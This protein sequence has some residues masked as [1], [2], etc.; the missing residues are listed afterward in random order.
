[1][2][3]T[4]ERNNTIVKTSRRKI[5]DGSGINIQPVADTVRITK[6]TVNEL[7]LSSR[8][9]D[10]KSYTQKLHP[11]VGSMIR[12]LEMESTMGPSREKHTSH[13]KE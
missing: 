12:M 8:W 11:T 1:M 4:I 7:P 10:T 6:K 5:K 2:Q 3:I 9:M 13:D